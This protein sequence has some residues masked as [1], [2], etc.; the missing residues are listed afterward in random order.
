M[1][2]TIFGS[3]IAIIL[4]HAPINFQLSGLVTSEG[5]FNVH[6]YI[7]QHRFE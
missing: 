7:K 6:V 4:M 5:V 1:E 3:T 2:I